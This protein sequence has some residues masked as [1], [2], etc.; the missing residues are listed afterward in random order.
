MVAHRSGDSRSSHLLLPIA[1]ASRG[2]PRTPGPRLDATMRIYTAV[3]R[4]RSTAGPHHRAHR[5]FPDPARPV[6]PATLSDLS[7]EIVSI[8]PQDVPHL[9]DP[10]PGNR[11]IR[12]Q[13]SAA[14]ARPYRP[15]PQRP[16]TPDHD[17]GRGP[18]TRRHDPR[19]LGSRRRSDPSPR[20]AE[21]LSS[22]LW[23]AFGA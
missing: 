11:R 13:R 3:G 14:G 12:P 19:L 21:Q 17:R 16:P 23:D 7:G 20:N 8:T 10:S 2:I 4:R 22:R 18:G 15:G 5:V 1:A 6:T 9:I